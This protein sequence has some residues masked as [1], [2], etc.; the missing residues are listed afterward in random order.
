MVSETER[1]QAG[2]GRKTEESEK[3]VRRKGSARKWW[4]DGWDG[5]AQCVREVVRDGDDGGRRT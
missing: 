3:R 2:G 5:F 4:T 1:C